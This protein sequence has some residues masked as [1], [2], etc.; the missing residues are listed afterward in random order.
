M[1][2]ERFGNGRV[3]VRHRDETAARMRGDGLGVHLADA[4][5]AKETDF[6]HSSIPSRVAY[7]ATAFGA[8]A[9]FVLQDG[10]ITVP[11]D[12][13]TLALMAQIVAQRFGADRSAKVARQ[14][15]LPEGRG[16]NAFERSR[17]VRRHE[18]ADPR[19]QKAIVLIE[20]RHQSPIRIPALARNVGLSERQFTR[21]FMSNVGLSPLDYLLD[22]RLRFAAWLLHH[23]TEGCL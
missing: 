8:A 22:T 4:A 18:I 17:M 21:L 15:S 10:I 9:H 5:A 12:V 6:E 2:R 1:R 20:A 14:L 3:D 7:L 16:I 11:G 13:S 23:S 19:I